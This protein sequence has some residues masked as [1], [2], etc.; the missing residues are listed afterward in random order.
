MNLLECAYYETVV[1]V[2]SEGV[3]NGDLELALR[4]M[5]PFLEQIRWHDQLHEII[6]YN[7]GVRLAVEGSSL[8]RN[9]NAFHE[10]G[11]E[12]LCC[13]TCV[14]HLGLEGKTEWG[15]SATLKKSSSTS[16]KPKKR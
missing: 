7:E 16:W 3:G 4:L 5:T 13:G 14:G 8:A 11:I 6:F 1:V 12:I 2:N 10:E 9:L 15:A